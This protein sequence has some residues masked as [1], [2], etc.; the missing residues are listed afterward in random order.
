VISRSSFSELQLSSNE[1]PSSQADVAQRLEHLQHSLAQLPPKIS[2]TLMLP[3]VCRFSIEEIG[4]QLGVSRRTA[5]KYLA[6]ALTICREATGTRPP[7]TPDEKANR[8][9]RGSN[10][11]ILEEASDWFVDFRVG[12]VDGAARARFDEWLRASPAHIRAYI[13][14]RDD[15][16]GASLA[17]RS[18]IDVEHLTRVRGFRRQRGSVQSCDAA[19]PSESVSMPAA[20]QIATTPE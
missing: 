4:E 19:Q 1:D 3:S 17:A 2:T 6:C 7:R 8:R 14:D 18:E 12:D 16:R 10:R 15:L 13:G 20:P 11:Q 9:I 5:R